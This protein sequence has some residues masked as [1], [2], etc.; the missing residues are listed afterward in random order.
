MTDTPANIK[1]KQIEIFLSKSPKERAALGMEMVEFGYNILKHRIKTEH[2]EHSESEIV[3]EIFCQLY[4]NEFSESEL[5]KIGSAFK[6][7][8]LRLSNQDL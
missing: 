4:N 2:P 1:N 3:Y 7:N 6:K 5:E 8:T